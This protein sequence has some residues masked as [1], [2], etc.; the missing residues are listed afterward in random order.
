MIKI[1]R[2]WLIL[3]LAFASG[4]AVNAQKTKGLPTSTPLSYA[5][6]ADLSIKSAIAAHVKIRKAERVKLLASDPLPT[7]RKRYVITADVVA[8]IRGA[9]GLPPQIRY[10]VDVKNDF[11]GKQPTL[12]KADMIVFGV[13]VPNRPGEVQLVAPDAQVPMTPELAAQV[14]GVL[15]ALTRDDAPPQILGVGDAFHVPG[16]LSGQG[17][18][19]IFLRASDG[20]PVSLSIW[21]EPGLMPRWAVSLAE[22]VDQNAGPPR[23]DTLLWFRLA[24][25][26]P[27]TLPVD[28][29][30]AL[31]PDAA[32]IA[33]QDYQTVLSGLGTCKRT[34]TS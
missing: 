20:R 5:D 2:P 6:V 21:R 32:Q 27:R 7:D 12:K 10:L 4:G 14:R 16:S 18:T 30:A 33:A 15:A 9:G 8:L 11:K 22:I 17:E 13:A 26:L 23:P 31:G 19:Q 28:S 24:C 3:S 34:R 25:F 29:T 1:L